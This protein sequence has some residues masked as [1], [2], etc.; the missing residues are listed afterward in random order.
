MAEHGTGPKR[1]FVGAYL[2]K[3]RSVSA[4]NRRAY[5]LADFYESPYQY[6]FGF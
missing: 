4:Y 1:V 3:G 2:R 6:D 5:C